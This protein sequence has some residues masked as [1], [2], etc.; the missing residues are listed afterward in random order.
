MVQIGYAS[1][2]WMTES[3]SQDT[4]FIDPVCKVMESRADPLMRFVMRSGSGG[5]DRWS[6]TPCIGQADAFAE[7]GR[8]SEV[9]ARQEELT[10][11][12]TALKI[13][14]IFATQNKAG[15]SSIVVP[16]RSGNYKPNT[17]DHSF[18]QSLKNEYAV[19]HLIRALYI[20]VSTK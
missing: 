8:L 6:D 9:T 1:E 16:R 10:T 4:G 7:M 14:S 18:I 17:W 2:G 20:Y 11:P 5:L 15:S 13:A 3:L 19:T 12:Q